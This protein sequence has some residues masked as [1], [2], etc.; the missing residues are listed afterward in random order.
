MTGS[1][2]QRAVTGAIGFGDDTEDSHGSHCPLASVSAWNMRSYALLTDPGRS[3]VLRVMQRRGLV[4][5]LALVTAAAGADEIII[6][7]H[8]DPGSALCDGPQANPAAGLASFMAQV[9]R[10]AGVMGRRGTRCA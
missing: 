9:D 3:G 10:V 1:A 8:P 5:P 6:E 4:L 2:V 7:T